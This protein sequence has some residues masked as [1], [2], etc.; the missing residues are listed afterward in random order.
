MRE[1]SQKKKSGAS[2]P[3]TGGIS[4]LTFMNLLMSTILI[5]ASVISNNNNNN[6]FFFCTYKVHEKKEP[7]KKS[8]AACHLTGG[9][10]AFTFMN[11]LINNFGN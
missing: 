5:A 9:I 3:S 6:V 8:E 10:L 11:F 7:K 1:K 4:T 2:C